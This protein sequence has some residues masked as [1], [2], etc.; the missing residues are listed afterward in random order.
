MLHFKSVSIH[1]PT[2]GATILIAQGSSKSIVSIHAPT[3]GATGEHLSYLFLFV[4]SIHAPTWGATDYFYFLSQIFPVS[5][6]A[7]TWGA[8][9]ALRQHVTF[10]RFQ[11]T[12][13]H[14]VRLSAS[15]FPS[16]SAM[17]QSTHPHG[18]RRRWRLSSDTKGS[19]NP[20]THMGCD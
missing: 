13:P 10:S 6:H 9:T 11:S 5:I 12:H 19:F 7:P 4:V 1:A 15:M 18:V 14:G 16:S 17:F 8:T 3:W 20:R 2:W